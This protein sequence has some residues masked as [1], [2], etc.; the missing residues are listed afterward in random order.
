MK[1]NVTKKLVAVALASAMAMT[2]VG[3]GDE[4]PA[5]SSSAAPSSDAPAASSSA[6]S[7]DAA[8][9]SAAASS[10]APKE[11]EKPESISWWTHDGLNEEN[12]SEQW[13]A[14]FE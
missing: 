8:G 4:T 14:E 1:K 12:G 2:V 9:S 5:A 6:A 3:C 13:F 10:E 11:I 7:S